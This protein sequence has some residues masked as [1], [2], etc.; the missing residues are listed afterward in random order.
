VQ[1]RHARETL[2]E[3]PPL[4]GLHLSV[5]DIHDPA[6]KPIV[7]RYERSVER[8]SEIIVSELDVI[9]QRMR[10]VPREVRQGTIPSVVLDNG[11]RY[12][13]GATLPDGTVLKRIGA[14]E[15]VLLQGK[16]ERILPIPGD[17]T[18]VSASESKPPRASA[19]PARGR[20]NQN[21]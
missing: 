11:M 3:V 1:D 20:K 17:T 15:L 4:K 2:Q 13:E 14:N 10:F 7:V 5:D 6:G 16:G 21:K 9:R 18:R 12:F 19:L 8:P